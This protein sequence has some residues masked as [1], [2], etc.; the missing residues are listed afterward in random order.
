MMQP[1][2]L[3]FEYILFNH[4]RVFSDSFAQNLCDY[5]GMVRMYEQYAMTQMNKEE[6]EVLRIFKCIMFDLR[7]EL[8]KFY[9]DFE[10][11]TS[12]VEQKAGIR[13]EKEEVEEK[14]RQIYNDMMLRW[15]VACT[16]KKFNEPSEVYKEDEFWVDLLIE[17]GEIFDSDTIKEVF[18][19]YGIRFT[20]EGTQ[21]SGNE[22]EM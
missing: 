9:E 15:L 6:R 12:E 19:G 8:E 3:E 4:L 22:Q 10:S 13:D 1:I 5:E 16:R 14:F 2:Q 7:E 21:G 20:G 17:L 11:K 18:A